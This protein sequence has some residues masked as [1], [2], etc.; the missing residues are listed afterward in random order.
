MAKQDEPKARSEGSTEEETPVRG[1]INHQ[2]KAYEE[3]AH[4]LG[5]FLPP[6]FK[7]HGRAARD[8][9]LKSFKV[10]IEGAA[11]VVDQEINRAQSS[12]NSGGSGPTTTGK[13]KVKVD[14]S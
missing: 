2:R 4:A 14:V 9:F 1:F 3:A 8:E 13:S 12:K 10:L 7:A 6:D 11:K 5:A